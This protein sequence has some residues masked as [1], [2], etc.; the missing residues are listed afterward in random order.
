MK[1][2]SMYENEIENDDSNDFFYD[3][4]EVEEEEK[5]SEPTEPNKQ[6]N[7]IDQTN[8]VKSQEI[9]LTVPSKLTNSIQVKPDE[10]NTISQVQVKEMEIVQEKDKDKEK[11][12]KPEIIIRKSN[13]SNLNSSQLNQTSNTFSKTSNNKVNIKLSQSQ[14]FNNKNEMHDTINYNEYNPNSILN[15]TTNPKMNDFLKKD[16]D[17]L[18]VY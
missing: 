5:P 6:T 9:N 8:Q 10:M 1:S 4:K 15:S 18:L 17:S 7:M 3:I 13:K 11:E 12:T 14:N 2:I 16:D